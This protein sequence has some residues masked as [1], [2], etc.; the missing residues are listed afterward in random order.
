MLVAFEIHRITHPVQILALGRVAQ[1]MTLWLN[2]V[3]LGLDHAGC[4]CRVI[5]AAMVALRAILKAHFGQ[6][7]IAP[8]KTRHCLDIG[9]G[10]QLPNPPGIS[11][12]CIGKCYSLTRDPAGSYIGSN[13]TR[14]GT[15]CP[16]TT[17]S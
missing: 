5:K 1:A 15:R 14:A 16:A 3:F 6:A 9:P 4:K 7:Y 13:Q 11:R 8:V 2:V 12:W 17:N 10:A